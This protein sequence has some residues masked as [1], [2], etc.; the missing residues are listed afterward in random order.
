MVKSRTEMNRLF[1]V[2]VVGK[3]RNFLNGMQVELEL[4]LHFVNAAR[5]PMGKPELKRYTLR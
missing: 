4:I 2:D 5:D 1:K 3:G